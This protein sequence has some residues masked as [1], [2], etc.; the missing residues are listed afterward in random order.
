M[1]TIQKFARW[2]E[3]DG[4][5]LDIYRK[6]LIQEILDQF[7]TEQAAL[8][9][10]CR[11]TG[12]Q[13]SEWDKMPTLARLDWLQSMHDELYGKF[14]VTLQMLRIHAGCDSLTPFKSALDGE[15][16]DREKRGKPFWYRYDQLLPILNA[17]SNTAQYTWPTSV[18]GLKKTAKTSK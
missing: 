11:H 3:R 15:T 7:D 6:K 13:P 12:L 4:G 9:A 8:R 17:K 1:A 18:D 5:E 10:L 14:D 16:L 2:L